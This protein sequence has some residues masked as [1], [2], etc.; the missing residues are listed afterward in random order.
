MFGTHHRKGKTM[1]KRTLFLSITLVW[2]MSLAGCSGNKKQAASMQVQAENTE[3]LV[4]ESAEM[5]GPKLGGWTVAQSTEITD[6]LKAKFDKATET[7]CGAEY[8]P[9]AVLSTQIVSG[10]NYAFLCTSEPSVEE[11]KTAPNWAI[12][13]IYE[14]LEG[15]CE[16]TSSELIDVA[17]SS[18]KSSVQICDDLGEALPG[19]WEL[20]ESYDITDDEKKAFEEAIKDTDG[21]NYEP[22]MIIGTQVVSG[23]NYAFLCKAEAVSPEAESYWSVVYVY[24]NLDGKSELLNIAAME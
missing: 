13:Y 20:P 11:L 21:V 12:V 8:K 7:L 16:M 6:D 10:T 23:T 3:E 9:V 15:N 1:K 19:G 18:D 17:A 2:M 14:N 4:E 5:T 24:K 22:M